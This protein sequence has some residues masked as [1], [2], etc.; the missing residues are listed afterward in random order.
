MEPLETQRAI[1]AGQGPEARLH[2]VKLIACCLTSAGLYVPTT[3]HIEID[4]GMVGSIAD[5]LML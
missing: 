3:L 2:S 5:C 1:S 4:T